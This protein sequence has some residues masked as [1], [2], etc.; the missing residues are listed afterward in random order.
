MPC[1]DWDL[2]WLD[3]TYESEQ[4]TRNLQFQLLSVCRR[5][6]RYAGACRPSSPS[7]RL[8]QTRLFPHLLTSIRPSLF[9]KLLPAYHHPQSGVG[10]VIELGVCSVRS[11]RV[12]GWS[13]CWFGVPGISAVTKIWLRFGQS[14]LQ[15]ETSDKKSGACAMRCVRLPKEMSD[16]KS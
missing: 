8:P 16:K 11:D 14:R 3:D 1:K 12:V 5:A 2:N 10:R 6:W 7:Q 13:I 4:M 9:P 15:N